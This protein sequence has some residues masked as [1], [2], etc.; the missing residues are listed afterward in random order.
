MPKLTLVR[1]A[2]QLLTLRG[3]SAPRRGADLQNPGIIQDGAVLIADGMI[4]EVGPSRRIENLRAARGA[5]EIDASGNVVMPG[6]VDSSVQL[7]PSGQEHSPRSLTLLAL[8]R[9]E[10]VIGYGT[11]ACEAK[12]PL[13]LGQAPAMKI[14]RVQAA[15][16]DLPIT[17]VSTLVTSDRLLL[18]MPRIRKLVDFVEICGDDPALFAQARQVGWNLKPR[19]VEVLSPLRSFL[20]GESYPPARAFIDRGDAIAL[21]SGGSPANML[22]TIALACRGMNMTPAEAIAASTINGAH[23]IGRPES[24]GSIE[25]GKSADLVVLGVP[26]YRELP[27]HFGVNLVKLV[28]IRGTVRVEKAEVQWPAR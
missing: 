15:L 24:V 27:Y 16:R 6:F 22:L 9:M 4:A 19:I 2:R 5:Q 10:E 18:G 8:H 28:M 3:P 21:A 17:M 23:A 1:G 12:T 7:I 11:T 13:L 14:L 25:A 20:L 26:D